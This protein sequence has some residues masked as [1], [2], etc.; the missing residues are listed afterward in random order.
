MSRKRS[1]NWPPRDPQLVREEILHP[2]PYLGYDRDQL[3]VHLLSREA[4]ELAE[5][6]FRRAAWLNPYEPAFRLHWAEALLR[7]GRNEQAR[8]LLRDLLLH[9][10]ADAGAAALWKRHWPNEP[11]PS[12]PA[13]NEEDAR[14]PCES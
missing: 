3:G 12:P 14:P 4:F 10:P 11:R 9:N 5:S 13:G 7:L 8:G 6:Q 1:T 2:S